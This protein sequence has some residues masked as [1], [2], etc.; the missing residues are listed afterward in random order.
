[1]KKI[2]GFILTIIFM[3]FWSG[4]NLA[5]ME[6]Q[7]VVSPGGIEA[8][9][10]ESHSIPL[11]SMGISFKG[12]AAEDAVGKEGLST[13]VSGLLDE[14]AGDMDSATFNK[15]LEKLAIKLSFYS[16]RD[17]FGGSLLTLSKNRD[18]AFRLFSLALSQPRFDEGAV[19]RIRRQLQT[20]LIRKKERPNSIAGKIWREQAFGHHPY[21]R[22]SD[23]TQ[24]SLKTLNRADL[25][26]FMAHRMGKDRLVVAVVGDINAAELSALLDETFAALPA[27]SKE[28][29]ITEARAKMKPGLWLHPFPG[30]Q[31]N[32][33]FGHEGIKRLD[34]DWYAAYVMNYILGGGGLTSRL[35]ETIREERGLAYSVNTSF[36]PLRHGGLF[37]GQVGTQNAKAGE[38]MALIR[39]EIR[40]MAEGGVTDKELE[41]AKTYLT[42][43]Y[44]LTFS[45][46][47]AI[48]SQML[49][50]QQLGFSPEYFDHRNEYINA[51]SKEK[52][53]E[54]AA[55]LLKPDALFWAVV[56]SPQDVEGHNFKR[57]DPQ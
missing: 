9:L 38:A 17:N 45:T 25:K 22:S 46:S 14:G 11:I 24:D 18:E 4:Q 12:G 36:S 50:A 51:V 28:Y 54:V 34:P 43:S 15:R 6:I 10:V 8:W 5:A 52:V 26:D 32:I 13:M 37:V 35:A 40:K 31:S 56:G 47:G 42:G 29:K 2:T 49:G 7:R 27:H 16:G 48:V 21:G 23:G 30:K 41:D 57:L 39:E 1:M 53:A 20:N 3:T 44:A 55:K 19:E 33:I